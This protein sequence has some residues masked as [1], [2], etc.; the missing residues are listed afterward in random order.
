MNSDFDLFRQ[1]AMSDADKKRASQKQYRKKKAKQAAEERGISPENY[2]LY[3]LAKRNG[4]KYYHVGKP[5]ACPC[6]CS[7]FIVYNLKCV[8][9]KKRETSER[10]TRL[11]QKIKN[12]KS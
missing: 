2:R 4:E 3:E 1:Q 7:T 5:D 11:W 9:C 8:D 10:M 12:I 6:G